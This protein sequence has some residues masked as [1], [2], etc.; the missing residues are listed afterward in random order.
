[1]QSRMRKN[2]AERRSVNIENTFIIICM[3]ILFC[4]LMGDYELNHLT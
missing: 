4:Y 2:W 3:I 1:M